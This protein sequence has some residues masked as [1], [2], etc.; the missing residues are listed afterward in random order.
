MEDPDIL[1]SHNLF[2]FE[3]DVLLSRAVANKLVRTNPT[4]PYPSHSP[5]QWTLPHP[6]S[7]SPSTAHVE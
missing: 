2:G 5:D 3:F 4:S 6:R 1:V 7:S